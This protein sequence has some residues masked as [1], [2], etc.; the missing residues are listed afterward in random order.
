MAPLSAI[1]LVGG[2]LRLPLVTY[3]F[4]LL[5]GIAGRTILLL[6]LFPLFWSG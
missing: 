2:F 4:L 3:A 1:G 6:A 5:L